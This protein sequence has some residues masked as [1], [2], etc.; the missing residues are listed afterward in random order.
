MAPAPVRFPAR[1]GRAAGPLD[2]RMLDGG[3]SPFMRMYVT[4]LP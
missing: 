4:M 2:Q 3:V 1:P